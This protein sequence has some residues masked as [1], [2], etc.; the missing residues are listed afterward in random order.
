M[1][2]QMFIPGTQ[3]QTAQ[4]SPEN[5]GNPDAN[6]S[7]IPGQNPDAGSAN[8]SDRIYGRVHLDLNEVYDL[9]DEASRTPGANITITKIDNLGRPQACAP[10]RVSDFDIANLV[11][12]LGGGEYRGQ[13]RVPGHKGNWRAFKIMI[14]DAIAPT[15]APRQ[16]MAAPPAAPQDL[17]GLAITMM[18]EMMRQ[19]QTAASA[20]QQQNNLLMAKMM[21]QKSEPRGMSDIES[22]LKI[23]DRLAT[24]QASGDDEGGGMGSFVGTALAALLSAPARQPAAPV[25]QRPL[26]PRPKPAAALPPVPAVN[27]PHALAATG[28]LD[29]YRVEQPDPSIQ[30]AA[31]PPSDATA[32]SADLDQRFAHVGQLLLIVCAAPSKDAMR[33]AE[34]IA[35]ILG[36]ETAEQIADLPIGVVVQQLLTGNPSLLP[37]QAFLV[38][39]ETELRQLYAGDEIET[40][41]PPKDVPI[42]SAD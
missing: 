12:R 35:D 31:L 11:S 30:P 19:S 23:A 22:I 8:N 26:A 24:R 15:A 16:V 3:P 38:S 2:D 9:L 14:A 5:A 25:Q 39:V 28:S 6:P 20:A 27:E 21:E 13:I 37:H 4:Q 42:E 40:P 33:T 1:S 32:P 29:D 10:M 7:A 34:M 36:D 18:T 41:V 17:F